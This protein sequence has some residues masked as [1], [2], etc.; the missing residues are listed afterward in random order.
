MRSSSGIAALRTAVSAALVA[1]AAQATGQGFA[2]NPEY[3]VFRGPIP[4]RDARPYNL[5]FLQFVPETADTLPRHTNRFDFQLD[6]IN[7]TLIPD[8]NL[9]AKVV[10]DNE[11]QRLRMAWRRGLDSRTEIDLFVPVEWRN[12]GVL[13]GIIKAYH[14]LVGLKANSEDV[15]LGRD[16]YPLYESKLEL[17]DTSNGREV[18]NQGNGFGLGET[19]ITLKRRLT[20][21]SRRSAL[22]ARVGIKLPTGNP[23]LLLGSGNVDLGVSLDARQSLGR[24]IILYGN[25]GYVWMGHVSGLPEARPNTLETLLAMEYRANNRDSFVVQVDGNGQFVRTGNTF[26]DRSNVTAT[27]GYHRVLDRH[28]TGYVS[29]SESGHIHKFMLPGLSNVGP[30]FTLSSGLSWSR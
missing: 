16:H 30:E 10:E 25:L 3:G 20:A 9:G 21:M 24:D 11:Y 22:S 8:P 2:K 19:M 7:N 29:F 28:L 23:T 1:V 18:V 27:F 13:D 5:L 17:H 6:I 26:A 12:G 15:P 4:I 14:H